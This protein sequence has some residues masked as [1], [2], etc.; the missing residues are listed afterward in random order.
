MQLFLDSAELAQIREIARWG[1]IEGV[2]TNPTLI[3]RG[4]LDLQQAI[5]AICELVDGPISAEVAEADVE[6]MV[7]EGLALAALHPNVV[8]KVPLT[9]EG[10]GCVRALSQR[11]I[12]TN[13]TLCFSAAQGLLAARAGATYVSPF[14]GRL[15]DV[16]QDGM[17]LVRELAQIFRLHAVDCRV[18]AASIRS[19][20]DV[21]LA[22]LAGAHVATVPYGVFV[23]L[24]RHPLT[25]AG[26]AQFT[27]DA[28]RPRPA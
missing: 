16:G 6:A 11:G 28:A 12:R 3:A 17:A 24:V 8:V 7:A 23:K 21:T 13:V 22:A 1:V 27:A 10:L 19:P 14:V 5:S 2:T 9:P 20:R 18:L 25:E 4:A 15:D 26:L